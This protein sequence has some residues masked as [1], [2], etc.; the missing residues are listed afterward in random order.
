MQLYPRIHY[1]KSYKCLRINDNLK[2][3]K[4]LLDHISEN[5]NLTY[6]DIETGK[7][8]KYSDIPFNADLI[9]SR[10]KKLAILYID[11][12]INSIITL[13][14]FFKSPHAFALLSPKL[15]KE[16][17]L[18]LEENYK[19]DFIYDPTRNE[20]AA[21][22]KIKLTNEILLFYNEFPE[23]QIHPEIKLMLSTSGTTGSPKF[24]KLSEQNVLRNAL[25]IIDY[26]PINH[27]D[28]TPLNLPIYYSYGLSILTTNSIAGGKI[29]C[30]N[31]DVLNKRF[32]DD[33]EKYKFS[34][35]A[36]VPYLYEML[37]RIGF[38]KKHYPSLRYL[39]QAGG[40]LNIS[41][42]EIYIDYAKRN[43]LKFFVMY[44]QTEATAR[45][46][47]L[48]FEQIE[49]KKGSIGKAIKDGVFTIDNITGEL[50]YSGP[51]V[52]GGFAVKV[53]D[54]KDFVSE[55]TLKTGDIARVDQDGLYYITG[56][57]KR[58]MKLFGQRINLDEV[59]TILKNY[60]HGVTFVSVGMEDKFLF[61]GSNNNDFNGD[62][63][64]DFLSKK[65]NI[66]HNFIKYK[67]IQTIP[68]TVNGKV[69]YTGIS[70]IIF[71]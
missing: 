18:Q 28:S 25:S 7:T 8:Y 48:P 29:Y 6:I 56:R 40:K 65:L 33:F 71:S 1:R 37:N 55:Q 49:E 57:L 21:Y 22:N 62:D 44:G 2:V 53:D 31:N 3:M 20:I 16:F 63:A 61:I 68:L 47:Y 35:I 5:K 38:T 66:H 41:F 59:E 69:D 43:K 51:N 23:K 54:L 10:S 45:M 52:F 42:I 36:G 64:I 13:L 60:F 27:E 11:N 30:T 14:N 4:K 46:S 50:I 15:D 70:V 39:T 34:S 58:F 26:L 32:W 19:P 9:K 24:V 17:K 12:S 67:F